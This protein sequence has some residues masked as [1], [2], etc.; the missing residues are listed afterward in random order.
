MSVKLTIGLKLKPTKEQADCLLATLHGANDAANEAS[1]IA[2]QRKAFG[3]FKLQSLVYHPLKEKYGLSAQVIVRL[4]AKVADAYKLDKKKQR[5]FRKD[6]SIAF[7]DR[8]LRYGDGYVSI[9]TLRGREKI[10]FVCGERQRKLL[11]SRQ[12]ESDLVY[13][14]GKWYLFATVTVIEPPAN[15][16]EGFL[17]VDLGIARIATDSEGQSFSGA[18][19]RN[20]RRR[21]RKL[22]KKLQAKGTK[23][24]IRLLKKRS[25]KERSFAT[26]LNHQ[27]SKQLDRKSTRLNS[28][29]ANISYAVF[30]LKKK[31]KK[32][33]N[34]ILKKQTKNIKILSY[35]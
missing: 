21:H 3:T 10:P 8:I 9:W 29:H 35:T 31:K 34:L 15:E 19:I 12:G 18:Q 5:V 32:L 20:L 11:E 24:A 26:D 30:C 25:G 14:K 4:V 2:W 27:I 16:P 17:G 13:R 7:D 1:D 6:G 28:S 33:K 23:S 22:R